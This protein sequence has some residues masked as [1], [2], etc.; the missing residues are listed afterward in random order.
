MRCSIGTLLLSLVDLLWAVHLFL[1][2]DLGSQFV[3]ALL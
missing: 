2:F 1:L 3:V